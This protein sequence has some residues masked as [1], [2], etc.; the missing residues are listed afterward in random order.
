MIF[1]T[2]VSELRMGIHV[3]NTRRGQLG[4]LV[5]RARIA[6]GLTQEE[7]AERA[8]LHH[9]VISQLET[10]VIRRPMPD[11]IRPVLDALGLPLVEAAIALGYARP[12]E[13][14]DGAERSFRSRLHAIAQY[15]S[16][17]ARAV[18]LAEMERTHPKEINELVQIAVLL[19]ERRLAQLRA[20]QEA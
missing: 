13:I 6:A 9:N 16:I 10:G 18:A 14:Q 5:R 11:T 17:E 8:G 7:L 12:E 20:Q 3:D 15:E 19:V 4:E 2:T 1:R